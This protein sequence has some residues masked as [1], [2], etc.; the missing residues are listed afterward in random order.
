MAA[1]VDFTLDYNV[2]YN[3]AL[4]PKSRTDDSVLSLEF[5]KTLVAKLSGWGFKKGFYGDRDDIPGKN[6]FK[7][8]IDNVKNSK[9][10]IVIITSGFLKNCWSVYS[11]QNAFKSLLDKN[12]SG[13]LIPIAL[14]V[15]E[16]DIPQELNVQTKIFFSKDDYLSPECDAEWNKLKMV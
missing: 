13:R 4:S 12:N 16:H 7:V 14:D 8:L 3:K 6:V 15:E 9:K 5:T 11:H 10:T 1:K 2:I